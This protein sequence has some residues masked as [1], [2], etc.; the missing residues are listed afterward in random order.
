VKNKISAVLL[1]FGKGL[2]F[3]NS[4]P[5]QF[6][7][8]NNKPIALYSFET[9]NLI[10][11]IFEIIV[12][13]E[14]EYE[15]F[16]KSKKILKF[17]LGGDRRQDSVFNA[18]K[19]LDQTSEYVLIHD[20]ARPFA[21]V[22]SINKV[23]LEAKEHKAATLGC[24][25]I[26]LIKRVDNINFNI[27]SLNRNELYAIQTPQVIEKNLLIESYNYVYKNNLT[28][29]DDTGAVELLNHKVK[30]VEG[31]REN[32]KIT[33]PFDLKVAQAII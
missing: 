33:T 21:D 6:I 15:H 32:F 1:C 18:L 26:D 25:A 3:N 12:V 7:N 14:K 31:K 8:L 29:L 4:T 17:V 30:I 28:I 11:E 20:S 10:D 23:V 5:K 9:L 13:V 2:R 27:E 22:E 19:A 16:F 24:K